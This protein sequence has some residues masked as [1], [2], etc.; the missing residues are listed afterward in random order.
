METIS[1][2]RALKHIER[3]GRVKDNCRD[4]PS[5]TDYTVIGSGLDKG[6][7]RVDGKTIYIAIDGSSRFGEW[8]SNL[9]VLSKEGMHRGFRKNGIKLYKD[10][11]KKLPHHI[12]Y[13]DTLVGD[14]HSRGAPLTEVVIIKAY[15]DAINFKRTPLNA[16]LVS[17]GAPVLYT[18]KMRLKVMALEIY[19]HHALRT[20][21]DFVPK[22]N[23]PRGLI[24]KKFWAKLRLHHFTTYV[25]TLK[26]IK[27]KIDHLSEAYEKAIVYHWKDV[28]IKGN[29]K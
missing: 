28:K 26:T 5:E 27:R 23:A 9:R 22:V 16:T 25:Y 14:G 4:L 20:E 3:V 15:E 1:K 21:R 19:T 29:E 24:F 17:S 2:K 13:Y 18:K 11:M 12:T 8:I 10:L 7:F 6:A